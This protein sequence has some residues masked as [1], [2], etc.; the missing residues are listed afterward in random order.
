VLLAIAH[1]PD[2]PSDGAICSFLESRKTQGWQD[3]VD[4]KTGVGLYEGYGV[5]LER[6][7]LTAD[8]HPEGAR[9]IFLIR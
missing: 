8:T 7:S 2:M 4:G 6:D 9:C 5:S 3:S 1:D